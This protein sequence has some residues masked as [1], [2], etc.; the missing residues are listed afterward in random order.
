MVAVLLLTACQSA[1]EHHA[2]A[3]ADS[4]RTRDMDRLSE[5]LDVED[6]DLQCKSAK[7]VAW[8]RGADALYLHK[9]V[10]A[11]NQCAEKLRAEVLWRLTEVAADDGIPL[12]IEHL[13]NDSRVLRWNAARSLGEHRVRSAHAAL[14]VCRDDDGDALVKQWCQWALCKLDGGSDCQKPSMTGPTA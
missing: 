12:V 6:E 10:L 5:L 9:R 4:V 1:E 2:Q 3:L 11:M 7:A 14:S 13:T 8:L